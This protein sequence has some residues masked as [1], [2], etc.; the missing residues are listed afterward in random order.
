M[1]KDVELHENLKTDERSIESKV[2]VT[3]LSLNKF[4]P[5]LKKIP[6]SSFQ[7]VQVAIKCPNKK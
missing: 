1:V 3:S 5:V 4:H 6:P 7:V 2:E